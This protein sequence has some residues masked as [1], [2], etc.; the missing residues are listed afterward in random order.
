MWSRL[1][2]RC[3]ILV[4]ALRLP[5][6]EARGPNAEDVSE[7]EKGENKARNSHGSGLR[8]KAPKVAMP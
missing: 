8:A 4:C 7:R 6:D 1:R 5:E 2:T 3:G